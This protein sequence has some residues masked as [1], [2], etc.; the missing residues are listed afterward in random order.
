M[1][2][3]ALQIDR[4]SLI[5]PREDLTQFVEA[6]LKVLLQ[7]SA[8][9]RVNWTGSMG[10]LKISEFRI[11]IAMRVVVQEQFPEFLASYDS[12]LRV[13]VTKYL[14]KV[15]DRYRKLMLRKNA[16]PVELSELISEDEYMEI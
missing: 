1:P 2:L 8:A 16:D 10:K 6:N 11:F 3:L 12:E 5:V 14:R 15:Q 7:D 13:I 9:Y 4:F